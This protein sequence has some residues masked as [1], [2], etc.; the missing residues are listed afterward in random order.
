MSRQS[1]LVDAAG[2]PKKFTTMAPMKLFACTPVVLGALAC[3][4]AA[5][6]TSPASTEVPDTPNTASTGTAAW[7]PFRPE[8]PGDHWR[9]I[10]SPA[11]Y[12][13]HYSADHRHVYMLGLERQYEGGFEWGTVWFRNSFGQPSEYVY[14]GRR[15]DDLTS[16][17]PLFVEL[18]GG[19]LHGY[20]PPFQNKVPLNRHGYSPGAVLSVGW[21]FT[22]KYSTQVD[23]LG[24][25]A[26]MFQFS[27]DL[28]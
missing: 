25:A 12:H 26:L 5:A 1:L 14:A 20:E 2:M 13:W 19:V 8:Q 9:V 15:F 22:P 7:T 21:Q 23:V 3:G 27:V 28:P 16:Y 17:K 18:T 4:V 11:T 10:L 24:N 6:Q